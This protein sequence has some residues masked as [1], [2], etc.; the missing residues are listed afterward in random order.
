MAASELPRATGMHVGGNPSPAAKD[1]GSSS[2]YMPEARH[3]SPKRK[4][5][6]A[7]GDGIAGGRVG[8]VA[9][10]VLWLGTR[11]VVWRRKKG[12]SGCRVRFGCPMLRTRTRLSTEV[13]RRHS[14]RVTNSRLFRLGRPRQYCE[15]APAEKNPP[16]RLI[17][18]V[19]KVRTITR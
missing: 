12:A 13:S 4:I 17:Q 8:V 14:L 11:C 3:I 19:A 18:I 1:V 5:V 15:A 10:L 16:S 9:A 2:V 6:A 7:A